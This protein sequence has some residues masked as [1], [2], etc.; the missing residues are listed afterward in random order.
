MNPKPP[1]RSRAPR[2]G[3]LAHFTPDEPSLGACRAVLDTVDR[4]AAS[5]LEHPELASPHGGP[6]LARYGHDGKV[7]A[8]D[9]VYRISGVA[10]GALPPAQGALALPARGTLTI[11]APAAS[12]LRRAY[13]RAVAV[14]LRE[15]SF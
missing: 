7:R 1:K 2:E 10:L 3:A 9:A 13:E 4:L 5:T 8:V 15:T 14:L 6:I 11:D 12:L